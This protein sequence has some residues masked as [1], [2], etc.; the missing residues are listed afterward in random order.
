M[1]RDSSV[2]IATAFGLDGPRIDS[3]SGRDFPHLSIPA[4]GAHPAS[5]TVRTGSFPGGKAAGT[6]RSPPTPSSVEVKERVEVY[7]YS[8][9]WA[10]VACYRMNFTFTLK[11]SNIWPSPWGIG[12][13]KRQLTFKNRASY[14]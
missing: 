10:F 13:I 14:I 11:F 4:P 1:D 7:L 12:S 2:V 9:F 5:Y 3:W 8:T 6:W